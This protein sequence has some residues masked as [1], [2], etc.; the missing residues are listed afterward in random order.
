MRQNNP[1]VW[2]LIESLQQDFRNFQITLGRTERGEPPEKRQ[3][4]TTKDLQKKLKKLCE[5][6]NSGDKDIKKFLKTIGTTIRF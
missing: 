4:K 5:Y 6:Y 1:S 3:K 2:V